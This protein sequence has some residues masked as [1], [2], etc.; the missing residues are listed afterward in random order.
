[1]C[2]VAGLIWM[3]VLTSWGRMPVL[4]WSTVLGVFFTL[5][6]TLSQTFNTYYAMRGLQSLTQST[7]QTIGLTFV[8]DMFFFHEH[9]RKIGIWYLFF[10]S[11]PFWSPLIGNFL[12]G[13]LGTWQPIFWLT[14]AWAATLTVMIIIYG[15]ETYY[16]RSLSIQQQPVRP[17]GFLNRLLRVTGIWQAR[18][19]R[20]YFP[21]ILRSTLRIGEV[22]L[23]P[24]IAISMLFYSAMFMWSIGINVTSTIVLQTPISQGGYGMSPIGVGL[25][26]LSPIV[27][28]FIGEAFGHYFNDFV[29]NQYIKRHDGMFEPEVRLYTTYIGTL[30]MIPGLV[31]LGQTCEYNLHWVG[32]IFGIGMFQFGVMLVSVATIAYVLDCYPHASGEVSA[33]INFARVAAGFSVGYFQMAW[34][35]RQGWDMSFGLQAVVIVFAVV[36][37]VITQIYGARLRAWGGAVRPL[38]ASKPLVS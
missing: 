15:D 19:H 14:F 5:G 37:V 7:G 26:Y 12:V 25:V 1:M 13:G 28:I 17:S 16:N 18:N 4:F 21:D 11:A 31:L 8:Q 38:E 30:F 20:G 2:G 29:A 23:K 10:V 22:F 34:G 6:A 36:L 9:A 24:V 27:A 35:L 33:L 3:P 32:I